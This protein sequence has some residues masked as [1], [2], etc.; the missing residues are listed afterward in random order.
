MGVPLDDTWIHFR[1][2]ENFA[3]G[4]FFQFNV[5]EPVAGSTSPLW[6][7]VLG[8]FSFISSNFIFNSVFLSAVFHLLSCIFIY[9]ISL[10]VFSK[11]ES[12]RD[13]ARY[14]SLMVA[15]ITVISGRFIWAGLSGMET[16]LFTFLCIAGIYSHILNLE[17]KKFN[18]LPSLF[19][20]LATV[21][22]PEGFLLFAIYLFDVTLIAIKEK[23]LSKRIPGLLIGIL[24]FAVI[25]TPYFIFSHFTSES[26]L[27]TTF[28]GQGGHWRFLPDKDYVRITIEFLLSDNSVTALLY[29]FAGFIYLFTFRKKYFN[30]YRILNIIFLWVFLLPLI[31]SFIIPN[32]RHHGRYFMPLIPFL[33][34]I[35]IYAFFIIRD[36]V[37]DIPLRNLLSKRYVLVLITCFSLFYY[38]TFAGAY[39]FNTQNINDQQVELA[40]WV[41]ENVPENETI[42]VN[43]IGAITYISKNRVIDMAGLV[44]PQILRYRTYQWQ[45]NLDSTYYLLKNNNVSYVIIY[46]HWF[47]PFLREYSECFEYVRSAILEDNT[48]CGG[49]EM[50]VYKFHPLKEE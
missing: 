1:Y 24:I 30:E 47:G 28:R 6:V 41:K 13:N 4:L 14:I 35:A 3:K 20:A 25:T 16:S 38:V 39:G 34:L 48:I 21:S 36:K 9:K 32:F 10:I 19:I 33:N 11:K 43:D 27:P 23:N 2:A 29:V 49:E 15:L 40:N 26:I 42:A 8:I 31:S 12:T 45:D 18:L 17:A 5:G 7:V 46:D 22:R 50:K 37:K 44:T